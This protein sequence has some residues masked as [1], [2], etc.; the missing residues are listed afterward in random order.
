MSTYQVPEPGIPIVCITVTTNWKKNTKKKTMK[1]NDESERKALYAGRYQ[2][3]KEN[4]VNNKAYSIE[5]PKVVKSALLN[6]KIKPP[7]VFTSIT[8]P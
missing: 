5:R 1:L 2:H 4:G 7:N 3:R 8:Q 6:S